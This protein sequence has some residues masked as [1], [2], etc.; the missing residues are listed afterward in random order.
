MRRL[1]T[2]VGE[3]FMCATGV[4]E[5]ALRQLERDWKKMQTLGWSPAAKLALQRSSER[6]GPI[7]SS[8]SRGGFRSLSVGNEAAADRLAGKRG[9]ERLRSFSQDPMPASPGLV[10][11][12]Y[13]QSREVIVS[14]V[15]IS[16][17]TNLAR[18]DR[19][20][21][22]DDGRRGGEDARRTWTI[23]DGRD[24]TG[25]SRD[26]ARRTK[27]SRRCRF[28][29]RRHRA[30][31]DSTGGKVRFRFRRRSR[32]RVGLLVQARFACIGVDNE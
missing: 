23:F 14:H 7:C 18:E 15:S 6:G 20:S 31:A 28:R 16:V 25:S 11:A 1:D 26:V 24:P 22:M 10:P 21:V 2:D 8:R 17:N 3:Y 4:T 13:L 12:Q 19:P 30:D 27:D 5:Q 9:S 32:E 29:E